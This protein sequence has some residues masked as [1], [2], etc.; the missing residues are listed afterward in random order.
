MPWDAVEIGHGSGIVHIAPGAG[1]EDF[2]LAGELDLPVLTPVDEAGRFYPEYGWLSGL[3]TT[4]AATRMIEWL[5]ERGALLEA[6]TVTHAYPHCWRCHTP[7]I[8]RVAD[9]WYISVDGVREQMLECN[10]S[11]NWT[12]SRYG[13]RMD[14]WLRQMGDWNISRRRFYGMPLPFY[15]CGCGHLNVIGSRPELAKRATGPIDELVEL[16]RPWIDRVQIRCEACEQPV[17]RVREVGD[18]WLDAGIVP[19]STLGWRNDEWVPGGYATGHRRACQTLIFQT[20]R[21]GRS[22]FRRTG[23]PRCAS[24]SGSGSTRRSSCRS[25]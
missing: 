4:E 24:K 14:D 21:T 19:F 20:R 8:F 18:V 2:E 5:R 3:S 17:Q 13:K 25:C 15:P 22:G 9:D 7:L 23:L 10:Q 1:R 16:H 12:P 11:I 6:E